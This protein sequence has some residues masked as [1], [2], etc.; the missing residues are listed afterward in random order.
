MAGVVLVAAFVLPLG[1][2]LWS[3]RV[4]LRERPPSYFAF[5]QRSQWVGLVSAL[6]WLP[7]AF[8]LLLPAVHAG[9]GDNAPWLRWGVAM[10]VLAG[11]LVVSLATL[12]AL[13]FDVAR[14]AG[15]TD[16]TWREARRDALLLLA[17][18]LLP[19]TIGAERIGSFIGPLA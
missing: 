12:A 16:W 17:G 5:M 10:G 8:R 2:A 6:L 9:L 4:A 13:G 15:L 19:L 3:H 11:P 1:L 7:P 18:T 14:R